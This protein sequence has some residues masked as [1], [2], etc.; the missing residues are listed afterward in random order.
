MSGTLLDLSDILVD[1]TAPVSVIMHLSRRNYSPKR[2]EY[3]VD[4]QLMFLK[5]L[6]IFNR[7][8]IAL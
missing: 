6:L 3:S 7:K 2:S 4:R 8:I 1:E 5:N